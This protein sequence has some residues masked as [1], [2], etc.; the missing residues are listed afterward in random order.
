MLRKTIR[1]LFFL[2]LKSWSRLRRESILLF[3]RVYVI[4]HKL[5]F[6]I[7]IGKKSA[8]NGIPK[9]ITNGSAKLRIGDGFS[10][11]SGKHFNPIGRNQQSLLYVG[12]GAELTIGHNVGMSSVAVICNYQITLGNNIKIGGNT[13]IYD[14]DFHSLKVEERIASPEVKENIGKAA[15]VIE[16]NVFVGAHSIILKGVKIGRNSIVGAGSVV[17]K[18]IPENEVWAGNPAK[19]IKQ[20]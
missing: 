12:K 15:V 7:K 3:A 20:L 4:A 9:L 16:D 14:S 17:S 19:M 13:V 8:F 6:D 2:L 11:N 5:A 18:S 1:P 10:L